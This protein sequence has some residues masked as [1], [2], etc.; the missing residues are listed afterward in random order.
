M[1]DMSKQLQCVILAAGEGKRMHAPHSKVLC[2][3]AG[4][5]LLSWVLSAVRG[6]GIEGICVVASSDD[7]KTAAGGCEIREQTKRLGTG[8]AV[9]CATDFLK[10]NQG[11]HT[12][13][14]CGDAPFIDAQTILAS[15]AQH[16][17]QDNALTVIAAEV[18][19]PTGY[20]R[21]VRRGENLLG[22]VEEADCDALQK[23]IREINSGAYWFRTDAL[24]DA[25]SNLKNDNAQGEYY[26]TD[27]L[28]YLIGTGQN[29][30][31]YRAAN[32]N[33]VL[34]ANRPIDLL[35]LNEI[36]ARMTIGRHLAAGVHFIET[37]GIVIGPDV[38]IEP[39]ATIL[40][41]C[42]LYGD[43]SVGEG[44][45]IGPNTVLRDTVIGA[46]STVNASQCTDSTVGAHVTIGPFVQLRPNSVIGDR[47]KIGDFVEVKNSTIGEGTSLA[48]LT[49]IGDSDV[50]K[51]CN[52]GCGVVVVNYDGEVKN[53]T[54]VGDFAFVG[55]NTNLVAPVRVGNGA[56]TAAATTV[57]KDV[58]D[59]ALAVGRARQQNIEG[60]AARKLS[61]YIE[62]KSRS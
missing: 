41:N 45:V 52:F 57:T 36:A 6:A 49:Y 37:S 35:T 33:I 39:G 26:L 61:K 56:Y 46:G 15:Y 58:P 42:Q 2:E 3:V 28:S 24:L 10:S 44:A 27:A 9:M 30:G 60:W 17:E 21:I 40:P 54:T 31:C 34:G 12:L 11:G 32:P 16:A 7:V 13:V 47:V 22:I 1:M 59:G 23:E 51:H 53:R 8:H 20:G 14:L 19:D 4:K 50:G 5:P 25:L 48:H 18:P 62:K 38:K 29:A 43:S 55:C